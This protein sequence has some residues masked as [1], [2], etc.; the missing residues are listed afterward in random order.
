VTRMAWRMLRRHPMHVI[1]TWLA[2][3]CAVAVVTACGVLLE[4]GVR[5]HGTIT[6]YAAAPVLVATTQLTTSHGSGADRDVQGRPLERPG[7][8]DPALESATRAAPGV[9]AAIGDTAVPA[10]LRAGPGELPAQLHPWPAARLAPYRLVAGAAPSGPAQLVV[11]RALASRLGIGP[12]SPVRLDVAS[13]PRPFTVSGVAAAAATQGDGTVFATPATVRALSGAPVDVIGVLPE[14]GVSSAELAASVDQVLPARP[15]DPS[16][17]YPRVYT[18]ADRGQVDSLRVGSDRE[19]VIAVSS[20]FGGCALLIAVLVIAGTIGLAVAQR[21]RDIALLRAVAATPRQVR[22]LIVRENLVVGAVAAAV[23]MWPGIAGASWLRGQFVDRGFVA[24][25]FRVH[26]SWLPPLVAGAAG[27]LVAGV[28]AWLAGLRASR[29]RPVEALAETAVERRGIGVVRAL[30]GVVALAGGITL[31]CVASSATGD[32][33]AGISVATVFTLVTAVALLSPLLIRLAAA[34]LGPLLRRS[35]VPGRL[36]AANTSASARRLSAVLSSLV[37]AVGLGG[38]LWFV[39]SSQ[40]HASAAQR[41]AGLRADHVVVAPSPGLDAA[42][43]AAVRAAPGVTA[44]TRVVHSTVEAGHADPEDWT[45][46]G[47]D[48]TG[49]RRTLDLD[50]TAGR[51]DHLQGNTVAV[52]ALTAGTLGLHVGSV[53]AGWY[54]DGTPAD[55][56]VVAIYERGLGFAQFTLPHDVLARHASGFDD[57]LLLATD[58]AR[59]R[60]VAAVDRALSRSAPGARLVP[61]AAY[62]TSLSENMT[63]SAWTNQVVTA[64]LLGYVVIAAANSLAMYALARRR[65]FAT[66]RLAG[67]TRRQVLR[68]VRA[69]QV[70]L[71]GLALIVGGA[72]AAATLVPMVKGI[73]G[74]AVPYIP[75]PGWL[76]VIGGVILLGGVATSVPVRRVLRAQRTD[77]VADIGVRE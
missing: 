40:L 73:T 51:L 14:A 3:W 42:A 1:A 19:L 59:P 37:L 22:R 47:I 21:H 2:L 55:L 53:F 18:G 29:I 67:T 31:C 60:A 56:T 16:G 43:V 5:Y 7:P 11:D 36:A 12:G 9:R 58:P 45:A 20:V 13:G 49:I 41:S 33:A 4:S 54:A 34:S 27:L 63:Q 44:A 15:P 57:A 77:L 8:L 61:R 64:V 48:V 66:L 72:I 10:A 38:S 71:L 39:Q 52:D 68:M 23:G 26:V 74:R 28:A 50:V 17:A 62:R 75:W 6:R 25:T 46:Q 76:A 65:E 32:G 24:D 69:E 35:G 30:L 70:V